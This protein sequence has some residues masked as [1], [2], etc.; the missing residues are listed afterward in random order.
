M[1]PRGLFEWRKVAGGKFLAKRC[2]T[3]MVEQWICEADSVPVR[4]TKKKRQFSKEDCRFLF[5]FLCF[6]RQKNLLFYL[7]NNDVNKCFR[8]C[9]FF[10]VGMR[11]NGD[12]NFRTKKS[13]PFLFYLDDILHKRT[14]EPFF[15]WQLFENMIYW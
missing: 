8:K 15:D 14:N 9:F 13:C 5:S 11:S 10:V 4:V 3:F 12:G 1:N 6:H 2:E 7:L